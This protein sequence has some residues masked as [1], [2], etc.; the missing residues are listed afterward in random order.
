MGCI[1]S[2]GNTDLL[3]DLHIFAG[4]SFMGRLGSSIVLHI[5]FA[6]KHNPACN[7]LYFSHRT[8]S[9]KCPPHILFS[10]IIGCKDSAWA[11]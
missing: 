5:L 9:N 4:E 11:H 1:R 8:E 10:R 7:I 3:T 2:V 6:L